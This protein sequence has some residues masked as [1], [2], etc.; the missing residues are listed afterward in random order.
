M[1]GSIIFALPLILMGNFSSYA[2]PGPAHADSAGSGTSFSIEVDPAP[3]FYRGYSVAAGYSV[4]R[5][6]FSANLFSTDYPDF[7]LKEGWHAH[8]EIAGSIRFQYYFKPRSE[9]WYAGIQIGLLET[10][11]RRDGSS[12]DVSVTQFALTPTA[13]YR[14][15]PFA[16]GFYLMPA[17]GV[18]FTLWAS[19]D[20]TLGGETYPQY[21]P[22][23]ISAVHIGYEF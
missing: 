9:G 1:R 23:F 22:V 17:I 18:G 19:G 11:Y 5:Y 6:R 16:G 3:F 13:G 2:A 15:F 10:N 12:G 14:W 21:A 7:A 8:V 20:A 4:G